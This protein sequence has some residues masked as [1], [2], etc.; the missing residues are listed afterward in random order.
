ML[1]NATQNTAEIPTTSDHYL[2]SLSKAFQY[3]PPSCYIALHTEVAR[4]LSSAPAN[5]F[6]M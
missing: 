5:L 1:V 2:K 4:K 6:T 3:F